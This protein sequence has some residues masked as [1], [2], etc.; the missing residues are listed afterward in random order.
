[1][2]DPWWNPAI[3]QQAIDRVNRLGQKRE[4]KVIR[5]IAEDCIEE[6][7]LLLQEKKKQIAD[8][9]LNKGAKAQKLTRDDLCM[10]FEA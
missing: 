5:F 10:L 4:V 8:A 2:C 3:E 6:K 9:I 1:M 7:I